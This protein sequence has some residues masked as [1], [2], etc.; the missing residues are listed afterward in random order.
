MS[1]PEILPK[2]K[3]GNRRS[4]DIFFRDLNRKSIR[5]KTVSAKENYVEINKTGPLN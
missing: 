5:R 3:G 1:S 2:K 4:L